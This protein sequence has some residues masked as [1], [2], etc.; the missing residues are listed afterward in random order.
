MPLESGKS[1][2]A[3]Q[4]NIKVEIGAGKDP[5]QAVAIAY[6]KKREHMAMGGYTDG[7]E[8]EEPMDMDGDEDAL[9]DHAA[10]ECME[11]IETKDKDR[12][13]DAFSFL[14]CNLLSEMEMS[15]ES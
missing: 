13:M 4:H 1:K 2:G 6:S 11:A 14:L 3:F 5:K 15:D 12:F 9:Q 10:M 8:A 7:G